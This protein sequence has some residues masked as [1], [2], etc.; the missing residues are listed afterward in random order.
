M[1]R[2]LVNLATNRATTRAT[3]RGVSMI[4]AMCTLAIVAVLAGGALPM[5]KDLRASQTLQGVA[6][7]LETDIQYAKS[8]AV[9]GG[10]PVRLSAQ[11]LPDGSSCYVIHTGAANACR[12]QGGGQAACDAGATLL[13]LSEQGGPAGVSLAPVQRSILF[14]ASKGTVTPTATWRISDREGRAIH[15]IVNI[16]GRVRSCTP[17]AGF[18]GLRPC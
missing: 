1:T 4:E 14:D 16:M 6:S 18:A 15:Q 8:E 3:T 12:C 11:A 13:R 5:L 17:T 2:P 9:A 7:L 10:K